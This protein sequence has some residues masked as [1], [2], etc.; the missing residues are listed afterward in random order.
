MFGLSTF[1]IVVVLVVS[2]ALIGVF[3]SRV[4][5]RDLTHGQ[6]VPGRNPES[7]KIISVEQYEFRINYRFSGMFYYLVASLGGILAGI[8]YIFFE[9]T[10]ID[11]LVILVGIILWIVCS[12]SSFVIGM[13]AD[14][15]VV[16][17]KKANFRKK[18]PNADI[19]VIDAIDQFDK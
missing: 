11:F 9:I 13:C 18:H 3:N 5:I 6:A 8:N 12:I 10:K 16:Q 19:I 7:V 15:I 1:W 17:R 2:E 4:K 14:I